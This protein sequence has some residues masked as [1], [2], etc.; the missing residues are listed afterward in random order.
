MSSDTTLADSDWPS[1]RAVPG[2]IL[3]PL[4]SKYEAY[5]SGASTRAPSPVEFGNEKKDSE[6]GN[7]VGEHPGDTDDIEYPTGWT[8]TFIVVALVLSIFLVSLDMVGC[9]HRTY[10]GKR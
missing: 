3:S 5:L 1:T 2:S 7:S 8:F 9:C 4:S 10:E 6:R